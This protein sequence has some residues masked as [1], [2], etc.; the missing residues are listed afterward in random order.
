MLL[1]LKKVKNQDDNN[2][3]VIRLLFQKFNFLMVL[4]YIK[5]KHFYIPR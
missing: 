5:T 2:K 3:R 1:L 4:T